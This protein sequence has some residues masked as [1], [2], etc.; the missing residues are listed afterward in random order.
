MAQTEHTILLENISEITQ[1]VYFDGRRE[2]IPSYS[3]RHCGPELAR[4]F[5]AERG[6]FVREFQ[7]I[8]VPTPE[9]GEKTAW[10]TNVTGNPFVDEKVITKRIHRGKEEEVS[11]DN[12]FFMPRIIKHHMPAS[13]VVQSCVKDPTSEECLNIPG[14]WIR[15]PPYRRVRMGRNAADW[16]VRR[17]MQQLEFA[18][19][20]IL[21]VHEPRDFEPN[22][23]WSLN[24]LRLM[25]KLVAP[26]MFRR[27]HDALGDVLGPT[28][29]ELE[30]RDVGEF[31]TNLWHKLFF[32]VIDERYPTISEREFNDTKAASLAKKKKPGPK[33][34][35]RLAEAAR[36]LRGGTE[37]SP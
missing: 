10:V 13:Q 21:E 32:F 28:E 27:D 33:Q 7:T 23:A 25:A 4:E 18:R 29:E 3:T 26:D 35:D 16:L 15:L 8:N 22:E 30:N 1:S 19:G 12:P 20:Q 24:D 5:I 36:K 34:D 37:A 14:T 9:Y 17:D 6:A 31:A 2:S 11:I